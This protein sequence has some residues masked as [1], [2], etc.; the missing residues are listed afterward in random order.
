MAGTAD[1]IHGRKGI[2]Q[3]ARTQIQKSVRFEVFKRDCFTCQ[4]CGGKAPDVVLEV[5]HIIPVSKGGTNGI[6]NLVSAC[7]SCNSG[8][9]DKRLSD[10]SAA[11][12]AQRQAE[13]L[14]ERRQQLEMI[15]NWHLSL[16]DVDAAAVANLERLWA[17]A[18]QMPDKA[19]LL[20]HA[21]DELRK[22]WKKFGYEATCSAIVTSAS[23]FLATDNHD[24]IEARAEA[25]WSI[26]RICAI[27]RE[28]KTD[29]G[30][31]RLYYLRGILRNKSPGISNRLAGVMDFL[32]YARDSGLD[33]ESMIR[34]A[35]GCSSWTAFRE[36]IEEDL[37]QL[38]DAG[39][40]DGTDA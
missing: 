29:P 37:R 13:D 8:K 4:Y 2:E 18:F 28:E 19:R 30:V 6:L 20:D 7:R 33:V 24:D 16:L 3:M 1:D 5:D 15:A 25:F 11:K 31:S 12:Q 22:L 10:T 35:K 9:S 36:A 14:E 27:E 23:R 32:R 26:G 17:D 21:K 40:A 39:G 38:P 34:F